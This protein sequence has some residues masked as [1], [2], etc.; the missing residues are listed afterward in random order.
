MLSRS[1]ATISSAFATARTG[2]VARPD[3]ICGCD[4]LVAGAVTARAGPVYC[5]GRY[6]VNVLPR[7]GVLTSVISPPR[8]VASSRLMARP[9]PVPPYLRLVPA[10]AC[11]KG[12]EDQPLLLRGDPD[13]RI[14][15]FYR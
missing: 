5:N 9:S 13:A 1:S 10:S 3:R 6:S 15:D 7:P 2:S 4:A 11:W 14:A 12:F 8:S